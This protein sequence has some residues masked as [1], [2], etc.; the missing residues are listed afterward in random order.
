M[1]LEFDKEI[2]AILRRARGG[3]TATTVGEHLDAD[4]IS[5]FAEGA[6][7]QASRP[8]YTRHLADC[9]RCRK[10]LSQAITM[11]TAA[12]SAADEAASSVTSGGE[13]SSWFSN[14]FRAPNLALA[15]GALVLTFSGVLGYLVLRNQQLEPAMVSQSDTEMQKGGPSA[16]I[17]ANETMANSN[18][19]ASAANVAA[20]AAASNAIAESVTA[21][22]STASRSQENLPT[23]GSDVEKS[24]LLDGVTAADPKPGD[25][26]PP[27]ATTDTT[28][29]RERDA[30]LKSNDKEAKDEN[31]LLGGVR[32]ETE[33]RRASGNVS[34]AKK[35]D[36]GPTR[37]AGPVQSSPQTN[38]QT[39]EM[40]VTRN[41]GGKKFTNRNGAWYDTAYRGQATTNVRRGTDAYK[42]LD[43]GLRSIA[44]SLGGTV[45]VVWKDKAYRI[46]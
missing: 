3:T 42:N 4:V 25:A 19:S 31:V 37:S 18:G 7:P 12:V 15:M 36:G 35:K 46:Q 32:Q 34:T 9:D 44:D 14:L 33:D 13:S 5:A 45:V 16:G 41:A 38:I 10:L 23:V 29:A 30:K 22:N 28:A 11:N 2:D 1:E 21:N 39:Y 20:N 40:P 43:S 26:P 17:E 6:L 8:V 27:A 24:I